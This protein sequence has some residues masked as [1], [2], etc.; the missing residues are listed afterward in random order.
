M[1]DNEVL[2]LDDNDA[3]VIA[4]RNTEQAL[5]DFY[6]L[7]AKTHYVTL[8][9]SGIRIRVSEIGSGKPVLIV[10]GNTG[11]VFP[12]ASLL[13]RLKGRRIIAINRPGG[14]L[15][16]GID[17]RKLNLREFAVQTITAVLDAFKIDSAPIIAHSIGGHMSLWMAMDKPERVTAL[18]LLGVP[19]NLIS[20]RPPIALRL[21]S[22][23]VLNGFLFKLITP[24]K[25]DYSFKALSFMGHS[26]ATCAGQPKELAD[27]Y[28]SFQK[29][30]N[31]RISSLSL[32]EKTNRL[33]GFIPEIKIT[34]TQLKSVRQPTLF[35]WGTN[36]PFGS[37]ETGLQISKNIPS[38]AFRA[39]AGV[40]H[41][42]WLDSPEE[43]G[44]L[45]LDFL[46]DY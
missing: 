24:K 22:L 6:G 35:L 44:A 19:G 12:L 39:I 29:L 41:L 21:L 14:G 37:A 11:D 46:S 7:K 38:A 27:C 10:P 18:T 23:P 2:T 1:P 33:F 31:Y 16:E 30:P 17:H 45:A 20:T 5:F 42:P 34:A 9:G 3:L 25:P 13:A 28:Y 15:S 36:D 26:A 4:A 8:P 43:C 32:I 40:G